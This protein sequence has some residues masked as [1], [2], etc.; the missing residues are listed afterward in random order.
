MKAGVTSLLFDW[1]S[2]SV[3]EAAAMD[4]NKLTDAVTSYICFCEDSCVQT[5]TFYT[6]DDNKP[7][8]NTKLQ[9]LRQAKEEANRSE[10]NALY[11][12]ARKILNKENWNS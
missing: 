12:Q 7:W 1:T 5:K 3:F 2:W 8:F 10:G 6:Y 9:T 11:K 4:L